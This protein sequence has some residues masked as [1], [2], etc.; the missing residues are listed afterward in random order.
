MK[1]PVNPSS[2]EC[3]KNLSW[4]IGTLIHE[5]GELESVEVRRRNSIGDED[6]N[7]EDEEEMVRWS[8]KKRAHPKMSTC[9]AMN[10]T[11]WA[12]ASIPLETSASLATTSTPSASASIPQFP[13]SSPVPITTP[14]SSSSTVG[15]LSIPA[16]SLSL[17]PLAPPLQGAVDSHILIFPTADKYIT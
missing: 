13:H 6:V 14:S 1:N 5:S 11:H 7:N 17:C 4:D 15:T 12:L 2:S 3:L 8:K 9:P 10:F 16:P